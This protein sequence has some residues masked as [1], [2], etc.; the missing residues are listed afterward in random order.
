MVKKD[1][2]A[3]EK[4]SKR[5]DV[6]MWSL[7]TL[8]FVG[9]FVAN[10]Y[11]AQ[12]PLPLRA[13][14]WVVVVCVMLAIAY[15][16]SQGHVFWKFCKDARAEVRRVV[17]PSRQETLQTTLIVMAIVVAFAVIMWGADTLLMWAMSFITG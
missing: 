6:I 14:G 11:F 1:K 5:F 2:K 7:T 12:I 8:L 17:W 3:V 4:A 9:A 13:T 15:Q 16:S 10:Y